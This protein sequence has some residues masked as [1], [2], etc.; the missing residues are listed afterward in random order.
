MLSQSDDEKS[1]DQIRTSFWFLLSRAAALRL[2]AKSKWSKLNCGHFAQKIWPKKGHFSF[3]VLLEI[4]KPFSLKPSQS[5]SWGRFYVL[6][7]NAKTC[8]AAVNICLLNSCWTTGLNDIVGWEHHL[9]PG[10]QR[11]STAFL[12]LDFVL[13]SSLIYFIFICF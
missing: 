9:V 6:D 11:K 5:S 12:I 8:S 4:P 7:F 1:G 2:T 10:T 3:V 13:S